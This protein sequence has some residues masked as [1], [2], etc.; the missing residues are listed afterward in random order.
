MNLLVLALYWLSWIITTGTIIFAGLFFLRVILKW[1]NVNPFAKIPYHLTRIT[2]PMVRPLRSQFAGPTLRYDLIPLL[3]GIMIL[4]VGLFIASML[5][6]LGAIMQLVGF[7]VNSGQAVSSGMLAALV[8]LLGLLYVVAIFLRLFLPFFGVGYMNRFFR[9][10]FV[11][12]E[13]L[14]KPL[15]RFLVFGMFDFSPIVAMFLV[16]LLVGLIAN[17]IAGVG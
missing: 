3:M 10:L 2:E 17:A 9:F 1:M 4:V 8:R 5:G 7:L 16:Q 15:R 12:T 6:Q 14:L 13:P 11:I